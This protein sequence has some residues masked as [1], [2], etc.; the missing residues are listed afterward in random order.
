MTCSLS[1]F[2]FK[3]ISSLTIRFML[4]S[5]YLVFIHFLSLSHSLTYPSS[6]SNAVAT[7]PTHT[8]KTNLILF[9]LF[10]V[11]VAFVGVSERKIIVISYNTQATRTMY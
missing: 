1:H 3:I 2:P 9:H 10:S 4:F 6:C 11:A 8:L 5:I 7:Q